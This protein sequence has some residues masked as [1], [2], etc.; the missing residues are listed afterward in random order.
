M[1]A[2]R[3]QRRRGLPQTDGWTV[4]LCT[5]GSGTGCG[6]RIPMNW[7]WNGNLTPVNSLL[8]EP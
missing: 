1:R 4:R 8:I 3:V 6:E 7:A 5:G 2:A